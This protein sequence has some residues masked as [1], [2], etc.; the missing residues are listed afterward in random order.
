MEKEVEQK[1]VKE[2]TEMTS[3]LQEMN[4]QQVMNQA[5]KHQLS[6]KNLQQNL[7]KQNLFLR[8]IL[9][10]NLTLPPQWINSG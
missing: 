5:Q 3:Q 1:V 6:L 8:E 9:L 10:G 4:H 2:L 7:V